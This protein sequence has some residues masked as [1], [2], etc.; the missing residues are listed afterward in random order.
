MNIQKNI[1][2]VMMENINFGKY[3]VYIHKTLDSNTIFYVGKGKGKRCSETRSRNIYWHNIVNKHGFYYEKVAE[4]ISDENAKELEIFLISLIG[5]KNLTNMTDGGDGSSGYIASKETR[6]KLSKSS[7]N[8]IWTEESR[9][10]LSESKKGTKKSNEEIQR[11][12]NT[13]KGFKHSEETLLLFSKQ[14]KN[15]PKSESHKQSLSENSG[16]AKSIYCVE[17]DMNFK[18]CAEASRF[19]GD[20]KKRRSINDAVLGNKNTAFGYTWKYSN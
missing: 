2:L 3:Y 4:N 15:I 14:R 10:K 11:R 8:R 16:R 5:R 6:L 9:K 13:R 12:S 7:K 20:I 18:S 17:L 1:K 19:L